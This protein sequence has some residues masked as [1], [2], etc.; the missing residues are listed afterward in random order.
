MRINKY[1]ADSGFCSRRKADSLITEGRVTFN[2][3]KA[4]LGDQANIDDVIKIDGKQISIEG[5]QDIFLA[6]NKPVGVISTMD[7][8]A[9]NS[10]IDYIDIGQRVF[11]VGR[12]DVASSGL[13]LLTNN[14]DVANKVTKSDREHEKEYIVKV[15]KKLTRGFLD[16]LRSGVVI[17]GR[18]T[19]PARAKKMTDT[20]F[21]IIITE[22]RNRQIRRMCEKL[23]YQVVSLKRVRIANIKLGTLGEGNSRKLTKNERRDLLEAL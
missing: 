1:I 13:M 3:K 7:P 6:F 9:D 20:K 16:N 8:Q 10:I 15:S 5:K 18:K 12:L 14:G 2:G 22:G 4:K 19:K 21:K 17:L 23:G 11:Y